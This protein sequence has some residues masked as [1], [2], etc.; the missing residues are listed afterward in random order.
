MGSAND[1]TRYT[2][3]KKLFEKI[4]QKMNV[5]KVWTEEDF[6]K[7]RWHDS[8]I[9][10]ISFPNEDLE[11]SLDI[12][13]LFKWVLDDKTNLYNFLVSPCVLFFF[14]VFDLELNLDFKNAVG[15]DIQDINRSNPR[16]APN[17]KTTLWDFEIITD[18]GYIKF[19]SSGYKQVVKEQPIY[20]QSQVLDRAKWGI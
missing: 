18:K 17:G 9:H 13:Y 12:D 19:E 10:A 4:I 15:L 5:K 8:H 1:E 3:N 11:F 7:M 14:D 20:S 16:L 6:E 2:D